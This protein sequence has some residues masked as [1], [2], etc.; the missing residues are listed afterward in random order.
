[1]A[2]NEFDENNVY[3]SFVKWKHLGPKGLYSDK[4]YS[5]MSLSHKSYVKKNSSGL[6]QVDDAH[7]WWESL[8]Q[9]GVWRESPDC[10]WGFL[11]ELS[12]LRINAVSF[13]LS[14]K[15]YSVIFWANTIRKHSHLL[16]LLLNGER[17]K[18]Y[19]STMNMH[20]S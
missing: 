14:I 15:S 19:L 11:Q 1:M 5:Q 12:H 17:V 6:V 4:V 7:V 8:F 2:R 3:K 13:L 10:T 18:K 9:W 16:R 20:Y